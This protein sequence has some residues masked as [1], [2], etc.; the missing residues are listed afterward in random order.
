MEKKNTNFQSELL[1]LYT[2]KLLIIVAL[3]LV[4]VLAFCLFKN[5]YCTET[6]LC[7]IYM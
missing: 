6:R 3:L 5:S 2:L 1:A 7:L 4:G